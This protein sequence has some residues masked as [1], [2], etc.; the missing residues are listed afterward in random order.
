VRVIDDQDHNCAI[1]SAIVALLDAAG[2]AAC[3]GRF[4]HAAGIP[5]GQPGGR[6]GIDDSAAQAEM[7]H[8]LA[9]GRA[10]SIDHVANPAAAT[11]RNSQS[12]EASEAPGGASS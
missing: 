3:D 12:R 8:E 1:A 9:R 7:A 4:R 10:R 11:L 5:R 2:R 6:P